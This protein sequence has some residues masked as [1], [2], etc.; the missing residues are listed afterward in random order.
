M[1][2]LLEG[3]GIIIRAMRMI[4]CVVLSMVVGAGQWYPPPYPRAGTTA[5]IHNAGANAT[6]VEVKR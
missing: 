1:S 6:V 2:A 5:L 3:A 4:A